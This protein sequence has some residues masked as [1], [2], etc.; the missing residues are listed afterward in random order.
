MVVLPV[1]AS[2]VIIADVARAVNEAGCASARTGRSISPSLDS[3]VDVHLMS[4][5]LKELSGLPT[6]VGDAAH[7]DG[8]EERPAV[9]LRHD[10]RVEQGN[11]TTASLAFCIRA[12]FFGDTFI[13][14]SIH[15]SFNTLRLQSHRTFPMQDLLAIRQI[16]LILSC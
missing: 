16:L 2:A 12:R 9:V 13:D 10:A 1:L 4:S 5:A 3:A 7:G 8:P 15:F 11:G 6:I 14:W